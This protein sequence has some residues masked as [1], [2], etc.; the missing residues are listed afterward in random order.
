MV[1]TIILIYLL[2]GIILNISVIAV[3][4]IE[5]RKLFD[6]YS[7]ITIAKAFLIVTILWLPF[8][9]R[10]IIKHKK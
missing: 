6:G 3:S 2:I 5:D 9:I 4:H 8:S 1:V 10:I 7:Y